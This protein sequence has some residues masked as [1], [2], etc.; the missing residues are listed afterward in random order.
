MENRRLEDKVFSDE[1]QRNAVI[2]IFKQARKY[3]KQ[4]VRNVLKD[5]ISDPKRIEQWNKLSSEERKS[6]Y[7]SH[8][9]YLTTRDLHNIAIKNLPEYISKRKSIARSVITRIL[10]IAEKK[11][12]ISKEQRKKEFSYRASVFVT[13]TLYNETKEQKQKRVRKIV[14]SQS[15]KQLSKNA[16]LGVK[17]RGLI[18]YKNWEA[19]LI[20]AIMQKQKEWTEKPNWG[21]VAE[22]F[23]S[24]VDNNRG[25]SQIRSFYHNT[26]KTKFNLENL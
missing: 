11:G 7:P 18:D 6:H 26:L 8:L 2:Y 19:E 24:L 16:K 5:Y 20:Y 21:Y 13:K 4:V 25:A 1:S 10:R 23:N 14:N 15:R 9:A 3:Y 22:E 12:L 17:A